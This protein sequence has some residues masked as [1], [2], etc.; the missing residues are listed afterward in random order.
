MLSNN[1]FVLLG[2]LLLLKNGINVKGLIKNAKAKKNSKYYLIKF[3]KSNC[4][5]QV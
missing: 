3:Q 4:V 1:Y 5:K 2:G